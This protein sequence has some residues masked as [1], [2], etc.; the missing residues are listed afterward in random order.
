MAQTYDEAVQEL[1]AFMRTAWQNAGGAPTQLTYEDS[2]F[3]PP[4]AGTA[5]SRTWARLVI[6]HFGGTRSLGSGASVVHRRYGLLTL[7]IF[8][9]IGS[10]APGA[11]GARQIAGP[12]TTALENAAAVNNIWFR[13]IS[14]REIG[15]D[16]V[17]Y[18]VHVQTEFV[19]D[20]TA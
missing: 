18:Q 5:A 13:N 3:T 11:V 10:D 1:S 20:R 12:I 8:T 7:Q 9:A 2:D 6:K 17:W 15:V 19:F 4:T 16:G 14:M